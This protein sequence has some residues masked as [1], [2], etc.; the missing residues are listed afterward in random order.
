[1]KVMIMVV[2]GSW[3]PFASQRMSLRRLQVL[4]WGKRSPFAASPSHIRNFAHRHAAKLAYL[5]AAAAGK[6]SN[7]QLR[8]GSLASPILSDFGLSPTALNF[9]LLPG[10]GLCRSHS[11]LLQLNCSDHCS[12]AIRQHDLHVS[13]CSLRYNAPTPDPLLGTAYLR[14]QMTLMTMVFAV[15]FVLLLGMGSSLPPPLCARLSPCNKS[16]SRQSR[17]P[18]S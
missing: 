8:R 14:S 7:Q 18:S 3:L 13:D 5:K 9:A 6:Q 12:I 11:E 10:Y 16:A 2:N 15:N 17:T 1:M 4:D